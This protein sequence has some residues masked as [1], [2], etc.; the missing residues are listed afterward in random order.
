MLTTKW[1]NDIP[2]PVMNISSF[3]TLDSLPR[4]PIYLSCGTAYAL[5]TFLAGPGRQGYKIE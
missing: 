3:L 5:A 1:R 2:V 4:Q